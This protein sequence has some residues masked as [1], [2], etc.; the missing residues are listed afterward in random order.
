MQ[1][2]KN[3]QMKQ[4]SSVMQNRDED[5]PRVIY[6]EDNL[7][8]DEFLTGR[9]R[10]QSGRVSRQR[11]LSGIITRINPMHPRNQRVSKDYNTNYMFQGLEKSQ[12]ML[13]LHSGQGKMLIKAKNYLGTQPQYAQAPPVQQQR[14]NN[15]N[16]QSVSIHQKQ[17]QT[18]PVSS[19]NIQQAKNLGPSHQKRGSPQVVQ[20]HRRATGATLHH[21]AQAEDGQG[22]RAAAMGP[23]YSS[24]SCAQINGPLN[25]LRQQHR[26]S[27]ILNHPQSKLRGPSSL[28]FGED[29]KIQNSALNHSVLVPQSLFDIDND[30]YD[31]QKIEQYDKIVDQFESKIASSID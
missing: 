23:T 22:A 30:D 5:K 17:I 31:R 18:R 16:M 8:C 13:G 24:A 14:T 15:G 25:E 11:P 12:Q 10:P 2:H 3:Y 7:I 9:Q 20:Q 1:K 21:A 28:A 19:S 4:A 29:L 27:D 6:D 26:A